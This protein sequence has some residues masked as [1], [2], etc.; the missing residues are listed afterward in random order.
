M[1]F[2]R[3]DYGYLALISSTRLL[4]KGTL[5]SEKG[6]RASGFLMMAD[7]TVDQEYVPEPSR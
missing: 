5:L 4:G 6:A 3:R 7:C 2:V 1:S